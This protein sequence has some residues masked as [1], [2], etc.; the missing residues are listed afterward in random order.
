MSE[1]TKL[2]LSEFRLRRYEAKIDLLKVICGTLIVGVVAALLPALVEIYKSYSSAWE[3]RA[4][5]ELAEQNF[6]LQKQQFYQSFTEK[7]AN[8]GYNQDIELRIRLARYF[9]SVSDDEYKERWQRFSTYL[10]AEREE[11]YRI[12]DTHL[13]ALYRENNKP[14]PDPSEIIRINTALYRIRMR[15]GYVGINL[16]DA[17]RS[18]R[19]DEGASAAEVRPTPLRMSDLL[20]HFGTPADKLS[21]ECTSPTNELLVRQIA[22]V[23]VGPFTTMMLRA[24]AESLKA[25]IAEIEK[26]DADLSDQMA[27]FGGI[28]VRL[29]RG[30]STAISNHSFGTA[31]DIGSSIR[32]L[33]PFGATSGRAYEYAQKIAPYFEKAGWFWGGRFPTP[34]PGHFELG[35]E[36][37][38]KLVSEGKIEVVSQGDRREQVSR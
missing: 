4:A 29:L 6:K 20:R 28:C 23:N 30:S 18:T 36:L 1:S 33:A 25:V 22:R 9:A 8:T 16:P 21:E 12:Y 3:K 27:S 5:A 24:A 38:D 7:F 31:I 19:S 13:L 32:G 37:F 11:N 34:D 26:N 14:S 10:E 35:K 2:S 17:P 15:T